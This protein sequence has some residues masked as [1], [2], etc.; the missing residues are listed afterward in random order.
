MYP[1]DV[2]DAEALRKALDETEKTFDKI[3]ILVSNAAYLPQPGPLVDAD[4]DEWF[5]GINW[6]FGRTRRHTVDTPGIVLK[7]PL[8]PANWSARRLY[9]IAR[10]IKSNSSVDVGKSS[11]ACNHC[12]K[13]DT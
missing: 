8:Q 13:V 1:A 4:I 12:T 6:Y 7:D 5:E 10:P 9:T 11:S 3:D 2:A